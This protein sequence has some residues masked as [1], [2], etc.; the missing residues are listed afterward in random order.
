MERTFSHG[1]DMIQEKINP[2]AQQA[3]NQLRNA[4]STLRDKMMSLKHGGTAFGHEVKGDQNIMS[5]WGDDIK[6]ASSKYGVSPS[7]LA[8][9][10]RAESA[11]NPKAVS[12][13]GAK[14]LTQIM[15]ATERSE[16]LSTATPRD[17]IFSGAKY[18]SKLLKL[19]NGNMRNALAAY[20]AGLGNV[21][22]YGGVP[23]Y[24]ET[25]NYV[26]KILGS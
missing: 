5:K 24:K 21:R 12:P 3:V 13:K 4:L 26:K 25:Q 20:N 9:L 19:T 10:I 16:G 14:G 6:A 2:Q 22:K 18:L 7:I 17:Q 1:E 23:P 11:G 8:N 15:P